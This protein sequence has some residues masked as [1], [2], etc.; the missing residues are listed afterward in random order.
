MNN[1]LKDKLTDW[2]YKLKIL[3]IELSLKKFT[4]LEKNKLIKCINKAVSFWSSP[5]RD[6]YSKIDDDKIKENRLT[7]VNNFCKYLTINTLYQLVVRRKEYVFIHNNLS[8]AENLL[9]SVHDSEIHTLYMPVTGMMYVYKDK[10]IIDDN[11]YYDLT[12]DNSDNINVTK[13]IAK[14]KT[15]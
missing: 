13:E 1:N 9:E 14:L 11:I 12:Q 10:I 4:N 15:R 3:A 5:V 2:K 7:E 6:Y 8:P